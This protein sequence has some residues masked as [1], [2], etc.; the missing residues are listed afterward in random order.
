MSFRVCGK[1][2]RPPPPP[3]GRSE[4]RQL[5]PYLYTPEGHLCT[6]AERRPSQTL[7]VPKTEI[8]RGKGLERWLRAPEHW[9]LLPES[10]V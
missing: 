5:F 7:A 2:S 10:L 6:E 3:Q 9:L 1:D 8:D 4:V